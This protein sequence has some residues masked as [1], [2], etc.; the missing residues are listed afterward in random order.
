MISLNAVA[1][2]LCKAKYL[3]PCHINFLFSPWNPQRKLQ[4]TQQLAIEQLYK[5]KRDKL[6]EIE[7]KRSS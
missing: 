1:T 7:R 6:R 2:F 5:I 4:Y 3:N